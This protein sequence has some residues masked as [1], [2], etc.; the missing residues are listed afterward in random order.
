MA[1]LANICHISGKKNSSTIVP[2]GKMEKVSFPGCFGHLME[3]LSFIGP[4]SQ[5]SNSFSTNFPIIVALQI[6]LAVCNLFNPKTK[7]LEGGFLS[8]GLLVLGDWPQLV[9]R[10]ILYPHFLHLSSNVQL[11]PYAR[12]GI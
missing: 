9:P 3:I 10:L 7:L 2:T 6:I 12:I 8:R 4:N 5:L 1:K 11:P